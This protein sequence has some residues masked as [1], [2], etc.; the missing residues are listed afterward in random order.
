MAPGA[1]RDRIRS[2]TNL[3]YNPSFLPDS[4]DNVICLLQITRVVIP[5]SGFPGGSAVK[6]PPANAGDEGSVPE[7]GRCPE[8]GN[9]NPLQYSCREN[10]SDRGAWRLQSMRSQRVGHNLV[11]EQQQ[12]MPHRITVGPE[13]ISIDQGS[14]TQ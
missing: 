10:P 7:W 9:G 1:L 4:G 13:Y 8:E 11:T 6:N 2:H 14:S 12:Y 5:T 3:D